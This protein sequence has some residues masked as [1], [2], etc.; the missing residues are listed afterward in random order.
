M[1][2]KQS[3]KNTALNVID[4]LS[5]P[6]LMLIFTPVFIELLGTELYG[7]WMLV[8]SVIAI[9]SVINIGGGDT[10]IRYMALYI[11]KG[12]QSE[13]E[14]IFSLVF[15]FQMIFVLFFLF[16]FWFVAT[17]VNAGN[18][19]SLNSENA[20]IFNEAL[21]YGAMIFL[22]K[23]LEQ[24]L[25]AYFKG[26]DRYDITAT[27]STIYKVLLI[28]IQYYFI[29]KGE[30]L[31]VAFYASFLL[32]V[33][34]LIFELFFL[35]YKYEKVKFLKFKNFKLIED[36]LHFTKWSWCLSL[37]GAISSQIDRILLGK[38]ANM[39]E[40]A[41]YSVALLIFTNIHTILTSSVSWSYTRFSS[42]ESET[43]RTYMFVK[44]QLIITTVSL[45]VSYS[46]SNSGYLYQL[47]LGDKLF[48][49]CKDYILLIVTFLPV[50]SLTIV[51][52][53]LLKGSGYIKFNTA[54]DFI[55]L[56]IR[57]FA[58]ILLFN[59]YGVL[60]VLYALLLSGVVMAC[61]MFYLVHI[62]VLPNSKAFQLHFL[63]IVAC[64]MSIGHIDSYTIK[65]LFLF[66]I[67]F[68]LSFIFINFRK[69]E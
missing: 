45:I 22:V 14:S 46:L 30:G 63:I 57:S 66:V 3:Y 4:T 59:L 62:K 20:Q 2:V 47:W 48:A 42:C 17:F 43:E 15:T 44:Y 1:V 10:V 51:P 41:Y 38:M 18:I 12:K 64:Y 9:L 65:Y 49:H 69:Q 27:L 25:H 21:K 24:I 23:M 54:A 32:S 33:A 61:Y 19:F 29:S 53:F 26:H 36:I 67:V 7:V 39:T 28:F 8:N 34:F 52:Y 13:A 68:I 16:I 11:H 58:M 6:L 37:V 35:K 60:G 55:T 40:V 5:L 31:A 50:Y 56:I